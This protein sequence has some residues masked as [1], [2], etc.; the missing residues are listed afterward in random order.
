M[1]GDMNVPVDSGPVKEDECKH[2]KPLAGVPTVK[3]QADVDG[4]R[5]DRL[6][7]LEVNEPRH[8]V[9]NPRQTKGQEQPRQS[10]RPHMKL[11]LQT[12]VSRGAVT[13]P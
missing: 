10:P 12:I 4:C 5:A 8:D 3:Y 1:V 13:T 7:H 11:V 9:G 6:L 2:D